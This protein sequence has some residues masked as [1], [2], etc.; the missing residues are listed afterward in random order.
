MSNST[1]TANTNAPHVEEGDESARL[2][3]PGY[4]FAG[5]DVNNAGD[6]GFAADVP[7]G[8][9]VDTEQPWATA[10]PAPPS[11]IALSTPSDAD[12][13][14]FLWPASGK[15]SVILTLPNGGDIRSLWIPVVNFPF[16]VAFGV[17]G[18]PMYS[19]TNAGGEI[20]PVPKGT[21]VVVLTATSSQYRTDL[22]VYATADKFDPNKTGVSGPPLP[23][24][25]VLSPYDQTILGTAALEFY[26]PL[27]DASGSLLA[28]DYGPNI[29]NAVPNGGVSFAAAALVADNTTSA[30]FDGQS[31]TYLQLGNAQPGM[32]ANPWS[33]EF[34]WAFRSF[35]VANNGQ[36]SDPILSNDALGP[37]IIEINKADSH[38]HICGTDIGIA[39]SS[40]TPHHLALTVD[41]SGNIWTVYH[42]GA[43]VFQHT[44]GPWG[45]TTPKWQAF[46]RDVGGPP[47]TAG[48]VGY[49]EKLAFYGRA[50]SAAEI[51]QHWSNHA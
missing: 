29:N 28:K 41:A 35:D 3:T 51:Q 19:V 49:M 17:A 9:P 1:R 36:N 4:L 23:L 34:F 45:T 47:V 32:G 31:G 30:Q 2:F 20:I 44:T 46:G 39:V 42:D 13:K 6:P 5:V 24:S 21:Q 43:Q 26:W 25:G 22:Y 27:S 8:N 12:S 10:S 48:P 18:M 38:L 11:P 16:A 7:T 33:L 40:G 50:L 15:A 37:T 14:W